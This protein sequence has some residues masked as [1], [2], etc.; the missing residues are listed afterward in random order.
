MILFII[1]ILRI[2]F[3]VSLD[4]EVTKNFCLMLSIQSVSVSIIEINCIIRFV[5]HLYLTYIPI[6]FTPSS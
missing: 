6:Y 5:K 4:I 3:Y 2:I 1:Y